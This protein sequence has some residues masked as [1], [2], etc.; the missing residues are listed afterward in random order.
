MV[1]APLTHKDMVVRFGVR[2]VLICGFLFALLNWTPDAIIA[3]VSQHTAI[4]TGVALRRLGVES[5]VQGVYIRAGDNFAVQIIPECTAVFVVTLFVAFITAYPA[6]WRN[7]GIGCLFGIPFLNAVNVLRLVLVIIIGIHFPALFEYV[8]VYLG[9]LFMIILVFVACMTWLNMVVHIKTTDSPVMFLVRFL[10]LST[11]LFG[12]WLCVHK[13][14]V[15]LSDQLVQFLFA[16][17]NRELNV[18]CRHDMYSYT[19]NLITFSA[20]VLATKT[21]PPKTKIGGLLIGLLVLSSANI[22]F[23]LLGA[24]VSVFQSRAAFKFSTALLIFGR[25]L[26]P[27]LLW[28][29]ITYKVLFKR[30]GIFLCPLCGEEKVGIVEHITAKHG[31]RSLKDKRVKALLEAENG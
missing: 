26:L 22:L 9:Q 11:I 14:Y 28:T 5:T 27:M 21:V 1:P 25:Y 6:T 13:T 18:S 12:V 8:H 4:M 30:K 20:L 29:V 10:V 15:M 24:Y 23:R 17:K 3:P 16:F 19:F 2:F 7:K 31:R